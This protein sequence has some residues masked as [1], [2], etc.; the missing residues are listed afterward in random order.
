MNNNTV[1]GTLGMVNLRDTSTVGWQWTGNQYWRDPQAKVWT[2]RDTNY[3]LADW[4]VATGLGATDQATLGQPG[5][6]RVFVRA[7][8]YEPGRAIA[9]VFNWPHQGTVPVDL[10]G[11]LKI[12]DRFEVHNVQDLWG[13]PV[14]TGTYGGGAVILPMNGVTPPLP[15][16]GSPAAP[17]KTGPDLD[18]FLV[19]R[20]P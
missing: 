13:T 7:N 17:I 4:K 5:Q 10:S 15:I 12:G 9:T 3:A 1:V 16:G 8:Q 19:T 18:V 14:T 6:P 11:V 20:A 2:F